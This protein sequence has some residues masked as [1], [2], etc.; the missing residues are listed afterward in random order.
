QRP[1]AVTTQPLSDRPAGPDP[2][3]RRPLVDHDH[4]DLA[5]TASKGDLVPGEQGE[6]LNR[7]V[8]LPGPLLGWS[9]PDLRRPH[10]TRF[11]QF[12][13]CYPAIGRSDDD[14]IFVADC[15][16]GRNRPQVGFPDDMSG[17]AMKS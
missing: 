3:K 2:V 1:G 17:L 5:V 4:V 13:R 8:C 7:T 11:S 14:P 6:G 10:G 16:G 15:P 12:E 9:C